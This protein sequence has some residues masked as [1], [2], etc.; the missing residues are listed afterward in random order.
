L[1]NSV[2][3]TGAN[4]YVGSIT[5]SELVQARCGMETIVA[6]DI[7]IPEPTSQLK[8]VKYV[9]ADIR[10]QEMEQIL[11]DNK[12][13]TVVHLVSIVTPPKGEGRQFAYSVDVEGTRNLL[14]ACVKAGVKKFI[15]TSSGASYGYHAD[16]PTWLVETDALRGNTE[17]AY[18]DHK[19]QQEE[20]LAEYR[21][22]HP[23]LKQ[24]VLRPGTIIGKNADNQI[25][26]MFKRAVIK[27]I[28]GTDTP[29][30]FIWDVDMAR[31]LVKGILEE[32]EGIYNV[33]G[34]GALT[35]S[36]LAK[37]LHKPFVRFPAWM[38][39]SVLAVGNRLGL[40]QYGP[41]QLK[42]LQYRPALLNTRLKEEFGYIPEFTSE[43]AFNYFVKMNLKIDNQ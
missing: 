14:E 26:D 31:I 32:N 8:G 37:K 2:L 1:R 16:N 35:L 41:E 4:G 21:K 5:L 42:F 6:Q 28:C 15:I 13:D 34:D 9:K 39:R 27:G 12:I 33:A 20:I 18:S 22:S 25:I 7:R 30:V 40:T 29:F 17:F 23:Q 19:R 11:V 10:S 24:L 43:Q 3:I 38:L 36:E